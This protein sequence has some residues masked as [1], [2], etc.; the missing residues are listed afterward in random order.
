MATMDLIKLN[1]G[2]PANFLDIGGTAQAE[3]VIE[4][5]KILLSD[6]NSKAV[7]INIFGGIVRCDVVAQ[8]IVDASKLLSIKVPLVVR[9]QGTNVDK[10]KDI[11]AQSNLPIV[12]ISD[13]DSAAKKAV[14]YALGGKFS[15]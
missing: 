14:Q 3:Q 1:G 9:L 10:A 4:A 8:G 12:F 11:I 13:L 6:P 2:M 15:H 7:L 5:F